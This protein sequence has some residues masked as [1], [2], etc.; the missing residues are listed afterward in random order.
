MVFICS[1]PITLYLFPFS[2]VIFAR[3]NV[4]ALEYSISAIFKRRNENTIMI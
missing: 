4:L 3:T 2:T 1:N